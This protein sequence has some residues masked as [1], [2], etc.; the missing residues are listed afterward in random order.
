METGRRRVPLSFMVS[1]KVPMASTTE[2]VGPA[3]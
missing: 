3:E 2:N 1:T